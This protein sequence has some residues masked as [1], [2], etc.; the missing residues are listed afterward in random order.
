MI[1]ERIRGTKR[2]VRMFG[3]AKKEDWPLEVKSDFS[4]NS[5]NSTVGSRIL[6]T[7]DRVRVWA[8]ELQPGERLGAHRHNF[9]YFWIALTEGVGRQHRGDGSTSVV[10]YHEG[11]TRHIEF[12]PGEYLLH[13]LENAGDAPLAFVTV[14]F[15]GDSERLHVSSVATTE[16]VG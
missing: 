14:E 8:I 10:T 2:L 11:E 15:L 12:G 5:R 3:A 7:N 1:Y 13:D 6:L 9:N 4:A 16:E